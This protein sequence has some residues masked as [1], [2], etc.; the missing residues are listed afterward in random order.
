MKD[1]IWGLMADW[2]LP[3]DSWSR[4]APVESG[5]FCDLGP[6]NMISP[7]EDQ[8]FKWRLRP[9]R[10]YFWRKKVEGVSLEA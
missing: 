7:A 2:T 9:L 4:S 5:G 3:K 1:N 6:L 10:D 8:L